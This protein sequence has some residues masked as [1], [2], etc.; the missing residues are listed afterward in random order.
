MRKLRERPVENI[1]MKLGKRKSLEKIR[2]IPTLTTTTNPFATSRLELGIPDKCSKHSY[3][4]TANEII[5]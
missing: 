3:V 1:G 2:T 4:G 5:N